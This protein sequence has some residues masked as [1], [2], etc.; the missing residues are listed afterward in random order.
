MTSASLTVEIFAKA[1]FQHANFFANTVVHIE[2]GTFWTCQTIANQFDFFASA[3]VSVKPVAIFAFQNAILL[4]LASF[5][6]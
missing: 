5:F 6:N 3:S 1:A 2:F 4:T